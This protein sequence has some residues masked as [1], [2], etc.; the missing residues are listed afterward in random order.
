MKH[1]MK[2]PRQPDSQNAVTKIVNLNAIN[3]DKVRQMK[4]F[5]KDL[6]DNINASTLRVTVF[7]NANPFHASAAHGEGPRARTD[8]NG[9][10]A[11]CHIRHVDAQDYVA[12]VWLE[13][14]VWGDCFL[15]EETTTL[16]GRRG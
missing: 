9:H 6:C 16:E 2:F 3:M 13:V 8:L 10:V 4:A 1:G 12:L 15:I 7:N 5:Q 11:S 14:V